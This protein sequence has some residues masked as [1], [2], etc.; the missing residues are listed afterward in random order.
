MIIIG[1]FHAAGERSRPTRV[2]YPLASW[3]H[4]PPSVSD[5]TIALNGDVAISANKDLPNNGTGTFASDTGS[6]LLHNDGSTAAGKVFHKI[7][8]GT[9]SAYTGYAQLGADLST[10]TP[11]HRPTDHPN[12]RHDTPTHRPTDRGPHRS[13]SRGTLRGAARPWHALAPCRLNTALMTSSLSKGQ[14][15]SLRDG[16]SGVPSLT[17]V[18]G[19][20]RMRKVHLQLRA[21]LFWVPS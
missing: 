3:W 9:F 20:Y 14:A 21:K 12:S 4:H 8:A 11:T 5:A 1:P 7:G 19:G 2:S 15:P 6:G 17:C 16:I 13:T 18:V 10:D